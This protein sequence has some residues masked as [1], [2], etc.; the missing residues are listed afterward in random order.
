MHPHKLFIFIFS[1]LLIS[2]EKPVE[3]S[4]A[5]KDTSLVSYVNPFIGTDGTGHTFP[6]AT[7]PFGM[8]Q[9][10]PDTRVDGS[11]EGCSG[12]HY[13]D[14]YIYGFSHTHLSG[15]GVS[16][17]GDILVM[18]AG[19]I[20]FNNGFDG[21]KGYRKPFSHE[22]ETASVGYYSVVLDSINVKAE[23][24]VSYRSGK[25]RYTFPEGQ[26]QI[27]IIDLEHR[28][29]VLDSK[30]NL[31]SDTEI[32]GY[33][34]SK[35]W[36]EDQRL[37]FDA[38]F[39]KPF[40]KITLHEDITTGKKVIAA[41]E[42]DE[43][44]GSTIELD[45]AISP[46]DE[47]GARKNR[48]AE[49][50]GKSFENIQTEAEEIWEKQL[51]KIVI[52]TPSHDNKVIFYTA[53]YHAMIAPNS[54]QDVDGRYRGM[55]LK[56]H[57]TKDFDYYTVFSLWDTYRAVHPLYTIIEQERTTDF[58]NT[59]LAKYDEGGILPIWDLSGNY[60]G[61]MI[62][63]HAV[64]VIAD[65]YLKGIGGFDA[66]KALEAMKHS[67]MQDH[68]GLE[69]Y[70]KLG[71]IPMEIESESVSKILEYAY[72]DWTIAQMAKQLGK[73]EDYKQFMQRAQY[74]K[75]SL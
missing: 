58:I 34:H 67:A 26:K 61:C 45:I 42:F 64:P 17:Y 54:Y 48:M 33:R 32:S 3:I 24:T 39:S 60:T 59:F 27:L 38:R 36:A 46:V 65:A 13:S 70:K 44:T 18:P 10:S 12:Y 7:L 49:I 41:F 62:G 22:N 47:A 55:D 72:D 50:D 9:L 2:C 40:T 66:E 53:M 1:V 37:F 8:M 4:I 73:E 63:Y 43:T 75:N 16:D 6:G 71:Y 51:E 23:L 69:S 56:I 14:A 57:Q 52:E 19:E 28:D 15:T 68:L 11:W 74:Y 35:A 21:K 25:H 31:L 5:K 30:L 20:N 29:M